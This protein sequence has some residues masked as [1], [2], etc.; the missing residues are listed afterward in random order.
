MPLGGLLSVVLGRLMGVWGLCGLSQGRPAALLTDL[1]RCLGPAGA[2]GAPESTGGRLQ[3][4]PGCPQGQGSK[5]PERSRLRGGSLGSRL[6]KYRIR[7][8][9]C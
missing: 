5:D 2:L 6:Y 3:G 7:E 9:R 4:C 1:A 8:Y